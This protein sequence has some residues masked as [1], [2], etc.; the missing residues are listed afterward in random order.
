MKGKWKTECKIKSMKWICTQS[1]ILAELF[2][3]HT[4]HQPV[5]IH[6][7]SFGLWISTYTWQS[8]FFPQ[9]FTLLLTIMSLH[10]F[11]KTDPCDILI[12]MLPVVKQD[13]WGPNLISGESK[14]L[15]SWIFWLVPL[16]IIIIPTLQKH[17]PWIRFLSLPLINYSIKAKSTAC[18]VFV[19]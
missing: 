3:F 10:H 7:F 8:T 14:I 2:I 17:R 4:D 11:T 18:C 15:H 1:W 13:V 9:F 5:A 16:Q 12:E 6:L 19:I